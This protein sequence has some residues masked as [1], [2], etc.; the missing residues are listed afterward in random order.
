MIKR[1]TIILALVGGVILFLCSDLLRAEEFSFPSKKEFSLREPLILEM[2]DPRGE[3]LVESHNQN[4]IIIQAAKIV[5]AK[6][7][8]EAEEL[9]RKIQIEMEKSDGSVRVKTTYQKAEKGSFL[10]KLFTVRKSVEGYVSYHVLV[11]REI[12]EATLEVTSGEIKVFYVNGRLNLSSTSGDLELNGVNGEISCSVTSGDIR[13]KDII[14]ELSLHGTSSDMR[15]KNI[16][17][18]VE[19]D[20]TSGSVNIQDLNG[21]LKSSQTSGDLEVRGMKGGLIASNTSGDIWI[22]QIQ[23]GLDINT[24]SGDIEAKIQTASAKYYNLE[25]VSGEINLLVPKEAQ[26]DLEI[27]TT[28]GEISLDIPL[29]LREVSRHSITGTLGPGG[30][31]MEINTVS[32]DISLEEY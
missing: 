24:T 13:A 11:P 29:V 2:E 19:L 17:G 12:Q 20:C 14:G 4:S 1:I 32:G 5:E 21:S 22:D 18:K 23:G 25:T 15:L 10:E 28:S 27:K 8:S 6:D 16:E 30:A 3:I 26:A 7:T 9:A 31:R